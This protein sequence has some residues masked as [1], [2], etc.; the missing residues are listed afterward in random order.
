M[1][2]GNYKSKRLKILSDMGSCGRQGKVISLTVDTDSAVE[3]YICGRDTSLQD[4][5]IDSSVLLL[6]V[7]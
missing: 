6:S 1:V 4:G 3:L 7:G 5:R 2:Y